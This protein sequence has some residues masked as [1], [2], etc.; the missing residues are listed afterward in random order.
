ML[1]N[2]LNRSVEVESAAKASSER[3]AREDLAKAEKQLALLQEQIAAAKTQFKEV[4]AQLHESK[5]R[6]AATEQELVTERG[7]REGLEAILR[8]KE[9]KEQEVQDALSKGE[10]EREARQEASKQE[11]TKLV[12]QHKTDEKALEDKDNEL[13]EMVVKNVELQSQV[14][15]LKAQLSEIAAKKAAEDAKRAAEAAEKAEKAAQEAQAQELKDLEKNVQKNIMSVR[16]VARLQKL[17]R[18]AQETIASVKNYRRAHALEKVKTVGLTMIKSL[19]EARKHEEE[20]QRLAEEEAA[21]KAEQ[22]AQ[23]Q[24]LKQLEEVRGE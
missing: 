21:R 5:A 20:K 4:Q 18:K 13:E 8:L 6:E 3:K 22:E 2:Y 19:S 24:R 9:A 23:Q 16:V 11:I 17:Y 1:K 15:D 7:N 10:E 12:E 14:E